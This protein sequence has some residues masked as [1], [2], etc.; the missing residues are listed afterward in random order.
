MAAESAAMQIGRQSVEADAV[1][2]RGVSRPQRRSQPRSRAQEWCTTTARVPPGLV[3]PPSPEGPSTKTVSRVGD[4]ECETPGLLANELRSPPPPVFVVV[5]P[6]HEPAH[7]ASPP[8]QEP[9]LP[10]LALPDRA[11]VAQ[12]T[13]VPG[14]LARSVPAPI[15]AAPR[16]ASLPAALADPAPGRTRARHPDVQCPQADRNRVSRVTDSRM[17]VRHADGS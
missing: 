12:T 15:H 16:P 17:T 6:S 13:S 11:V 1:G 9:P 3:P 4:R 7:T 10:T 5:D 14:P 2:A 8:S